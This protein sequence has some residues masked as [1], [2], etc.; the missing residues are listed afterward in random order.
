MT[1]TGPVPVHPLAPRAVPGPLPG[2]LPRLPMGLPMTWAARRPT[3][4]DAAQ[5]FDLVAACDI[6]VLGYPDIAI[7]DVR[8][9]LAVDPQRQVLVTDGSRALAWARVHDKAAGR[10]VAD[11]YVL[12]ELEVA[13]GDRLAAWCW[14]LLLAWGAAIASL[15]GLPSTTL[16]AGLLAGDVANERR[17]AAAGL[18]ARRTFWRMQRPLTPQDVAPP[19]P[20]G[21]QLR[22]VAERDLTV[23]HDIVEAAFADHWN[24]HPRGYD[25][26][27]PHVSGNAGFDLGL[28]WLAEV[29]GQ[30]VGVLIATRQMA[31][32]DAMYIAT[33]ATRREFRGRGVATA[34]LRKAFAAA[35]A[36]GWS[37]AKLDVD[38]ESTTSA[39]SVY[40]GV[41]L[42][43]AHAVRAWLREVEAG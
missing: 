13:T 40:A 38:S 11:A 10:T 34:L 23:V 24:H 26:W 29:D 18:T 30:P 25:E 12:P 36:E 5:I 32:E 6:A 8:S 2:L 16:D 31:D 1:Q 4:D 14:Q 28:W 41:G 33:L 20:P 39:P 19:L 9:D 7:G 22:G 3:A 21:V 27:W 37:A 43:V 17:L 35:Q 15:R 42:E